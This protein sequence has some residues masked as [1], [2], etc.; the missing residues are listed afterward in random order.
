[1]TSIIATPLSTDTNTATEVRVTLVFEFDSTPVTTGQVNLDDNGV[2]LPMSYNSAGGYWSASVTKNIAGN[3]T[4]A[5]EYVLGNTHDITALDTDSLS[6][7]VEWVGA[8]GFVID[9]MTLMIIG[10][11]A[12][13]GVLG[14]AIVASRRR[15][16]GVV[17]DLTALEPDDFRVVEPVEVEAIPEEIE[18]EEIEPEIEPEVVEEP[19]VSEPD[20][21]VVEEAVEPE[22]EVIEEVP[23]PEEIESLVDEELVIEPEPEVIEEP[24]IEPEIEPEGVDYDDIPD[25][26]IE[27]KAPVDLSTLTKKELLGM[28]PKDILETS[29]PNELKRLTKQELISLIESF[30]D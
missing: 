7:E 21:E 16:G 3:Y 2:S 15:R 1:V 8:P 20:V 19:E 28:I 14:L 9:T 5:V 30:Q 6:V 13:I 25:E 4:F 29:S 18:S 17:A 24:I 23:E 27:P 11:G 22:V 12:G 10:G 26:F